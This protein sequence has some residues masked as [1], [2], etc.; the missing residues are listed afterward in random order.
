MNT[1]FAILCGG[2]GTRLWPLS[3]K[4]KPKQF[5]PFLKNKS[6]LE[7]TVDRI[8]PLTSSQNQICLVSTE[9]QKKLIIETVGSKIGFLINEPLPKNTGPALL[10]TCLE[11]EKTTPDSVVAFMHSDAFIEDE[12]NFQDSLEL[13]IQHASDND[14]IVT[15]G[16]TPRYP[17]TG[18]GY[19]Q[20][21]EKEATIRNIY[22]IEQFHEKPHLELA[23]KYVTQN[24]MFW[25]P[26]F[27]IAKA[28]V[29]IN[30][31]KKFEPSLYETILNYTKHATGYE[32]AKKI[33][34]DHAVM[35]RT[36]NAVVMPCNFKWSDVGNLNVFLSTKEAIAKKHTKALSIESHNNIYHTS[37]KTITFINV[38]DLCV[39]ETKDSIVIAKRDCTEKIKEA[40]SFLK[41]ENLE[42]LL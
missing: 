23:Q 39:I 7:L 22:P 28:S 20:T 33:S 21:K 11:I 18:Y 12:K 13:A 16:I 31:F 5:I 14:V 4:N 38:N 9:E 19:I 35:E 24:N 25:N 27:F 3:R 2:S 41:K 26:G 1:F 17:A 36:K 32:T 29:F 15:L 34:F 6:L 30:E 10:L 8:K 40:Q 37:K 42:S